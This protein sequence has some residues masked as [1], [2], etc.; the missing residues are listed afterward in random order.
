M[1]KWPAW[2]RGCLGTLVGLG[3]LAGGSAALVRAGAEPVCQ[4][5][6]GWHWASG[7]P[8]P[9]AASQ[10]R[11]ALAALGLDAAVTATSFGEA[12][13]CGT[14][15]RRGVDFALTLRAGRVEPGQ[16]RQIRAALRPL[17]APQ[18]GTVTV[19]GPHGERITLREPLAAAQAVSAQMTA[20]RKLNPAL[21]PP[22][23]Y[24]HGLAYDSQHS[25]TVLF[26]GDSTGAARLNDTWTFDGVTWAP[27]TPPQSP[28][29]RANIDQTLVYDSAR[30]R[31]VLFGGLG[32]GS[33]LNDTWEFDGANWSPVT[34]GGQPPARDSHAMAFDSGQGQTVL[35][36]GYAGAPLDDTWTYDGVWHPAN[37]A[38]SPPARFHH[39]LAYASDRGVSV[40]FGGLGSGNT[41]LGDTWEYDGTT[42]RLINPPQSPPARDNHSL[43]YDSLRQVVVLFGGEGEGGRLNDTWEYDGTTWRPAAVAAAPSARTEM[44]LIYDS[45]RGRVIQFGG[46]YWGA[47][48]TVFDETWEYPVEVAPPPPPVHQKKV[49]VIAYN[50]TLSNGN[51]LS[52]HLGWNEHAALT[53]QTVEFFRQASGQRLEYTVVLTTVV[54]DHWP[55]LLDGY[56]YTETTYLA[57]IGGAPPPS[58]AGV[59]YNAIVN[60]PQFD[61]CGKANRGEIDEVWIYNG[62]FFGFW[63]STLVGPGAYWYNSVPVPGPHNCQR[64]VPI[65]GPSP[66]RGLAEAVHNFGHRTES[67]LMQVYGSWQ[68]NRTL[69]NWDRFAL[70]RAKSPGYGY[71]GCGDV[72]FPPNGASDYDYGNAATAQTYCADFENYPD[73]TD[74]PPLLPVT[75][76]AWGCSHEGY[77]AYW[78]SHLPRQAGCGPDQLAS[79]WWVY[80]V[81]PERALDPASLCRTHVYLPAIARSEAP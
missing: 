77:L 74:P 28:P 18:L 45:A 60:S 71:S 69:H 14:F 63:E 39:A 75:C 33:Y 57:A 10:A 31:V 49:Y 35:F 44:G 26:G 78:F 19:L 58:M 34:G 62:P 8:E 23:R 76:A 59:D 53:R 29:G 11:P 13:A 52:Q 70:T 20:W 67:A 6:A 61:I 48:L 21:A 12:D 15:H 73:L 64:L 9:R 68:Q 38:Q 1:G 37:P 43:V 65:M 2:A 80:V 5:G 3:L 56:Q 27:V 25:L 36:G 54:T 17:A 30:Q 7:G 41:R 42:W 50:P 79:D 22:G 40:L 81:S 32:A 72:H 51:S 4:A 46:G 24:T 66:E 16:A 47:G 55:V